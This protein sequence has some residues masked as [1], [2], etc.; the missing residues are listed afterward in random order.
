MAGLIA[1]ATAAEVPYPKPTYPAA[2]APYPEHVSINVVSLEKWY[3]KTFSFEL[4]PLMPYDFAYAVKDEPSYNHF[5]HQETSDGKTVIGSYRVVLP[6]SRTQIVNYKID[7]YSGF[8]AD[9]KY[10]G[11]AKFPDYKPAYKPASPASKYAA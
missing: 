5:G 6:D 8:V 10:E 11:E 7:A 1:V 9:V 4:Q 3:E 2:P